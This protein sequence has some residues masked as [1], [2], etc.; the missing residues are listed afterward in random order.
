M[1]LAG[2]LPLRD[3]G[4]VWVSHP[5][6]TP[7]VDAPGGLQCGVGEAAG[8]CS[9]GFRAEPASPHARHTGWDWLSRSSPRGLSTAVRVQ[10]KGRTSCRNVTAATGP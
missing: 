7:Q 1:S 2:R 3:L 9:A 6:L 5:G 10:V 8:G 4:R